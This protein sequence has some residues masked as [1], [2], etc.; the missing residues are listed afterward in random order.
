VVAIHHFIVIAEFGARPSFVGK[1]RTFSPQSNTVRAL[2]KL[3][4]GKLWPDK[5]D[6]PC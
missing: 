2:E 3:K 1:F 6:E 5:G 4:L